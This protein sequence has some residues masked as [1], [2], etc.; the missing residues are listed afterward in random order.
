MTT[1]SCTAATCADRQATRLR[2]T[3]AVT[4]AV[5]HASAFAEAIPVDADVHALRD[6]PAW[7]AEES[8]AAR[9][10][11]RWLLAGQAGADAAAA[12]IRARQTGQPYL[13]GRPD[14]GISLSHGHGHVAAAIGM[15]RAVGIDVQAPVPVSAAVIRRCCLPRVRDE[16]AA[17]PDA[18]RTLEFAWI[19]TVQEACVKAAGTGLAGRPW[20]IP[21]ERGQRT[22][23]WLGYQWLSLRDDSAVPLSV[24]HAR[25]QTGERR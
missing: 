14:V 18:A 25:H 8:R 15:G 20:S 3:A 13:A 16:L 10:L 19:W 9:A 2:P 22:G 21:V 1:N 17:L 5:A 12:P 6:L 4:V 7:R 23:E 24:A 11:L